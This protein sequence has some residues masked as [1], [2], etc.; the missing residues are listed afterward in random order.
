MSKYAN[1][2][3]DVEFEKG[4]IISGLWSLL[5]QIQWLLPK[6]EQM[7]PHQNMTYYYKLGIRFFALHLGQNSVMTNTMFDNR[8]TAIL[9]AMR[10][11]FC[12][13]ISKVKY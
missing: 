3:K 8:G 5:E 6:M 12:S 1:F 2:H 4:T 11:V 13:A 7:K 10:L 9:L